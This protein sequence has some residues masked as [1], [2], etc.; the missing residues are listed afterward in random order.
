MCSFDTFSGATVW[1]WN[2]RKLLC[3][4]Q[5][6]S[7]CITCAS[8]TETKPSELQAT[9]HAEAWLGNALN[10]L[11]KLQTFLPLLTGDF[12]SLFYKLNSFISS[13]SFLNH[14]YIF[15]ESDCFISLLKAY[16]LCKEIAFRVKMYLK[17]AWSLNK[18]S[19]L[20]ANNVR[21]MPRISR[22][23]FALKSHEKHAEVIT[24]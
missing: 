5:T 2:P 23:K 10:R 22:M 13:L 9:C 3:D 15:F 19:N 4:P 6:T 21:D 1:K 17:H 11:F 12:E 8:D 16:H 7:R 20:R 14:T 18:Y 24:L